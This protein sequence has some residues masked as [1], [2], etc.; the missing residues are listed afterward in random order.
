MNSFPP[1]Y[2]IHAANVVLL[3]AYSVRDILWFR[4][5]QSVGK[6][7]R[8]INISTPTPKREQKCSGTSH[9]AWLGRWGN[10][11]GIHSNRGLGMRND[12]SG[13]R[14]DAV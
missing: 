7:R 4:S 3:V 12:A 14:S 1:D 8:L 5:A 13:W 6:L 2:F 10:W 9:A 11:L